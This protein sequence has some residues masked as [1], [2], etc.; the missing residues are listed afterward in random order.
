MR[1][2]GKPTGDRDLAFAQPNAKRSSRL[3]E[4]PLGRRLGLL[5]ARRGDQHLPDGGRRERF[6]L[7]PVSVLHAM[8]FGAEG[9]GQVE[10]VN[11]S[12]ILGQPKMTEPRVVAQQRD[13]F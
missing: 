4:S 5:P 11:R 7:H 2:L 8:G 13:H 10:R 3:V 6:D 1:R 12:A 9:G